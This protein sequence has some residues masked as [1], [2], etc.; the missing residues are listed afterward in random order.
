MCCR[1]RAWPPARST[2]SSRQALP[3]PAGIVVRARSHWTALG[4]YLF[5]T[6][7]MT[8]PLARQFGSAIPGD[9]FDGWQNYWN[10]WWM[11]LALVDRVQWPLATDLLYYPTGVT[12]HFHTLNPFN[13]LISL[14]VQLVFGLIPAYNV[15]VL[16]S[17]VLSGYG[18]FLLA[19]W[20][21]RPRGALALAP[22]SR[23]AAAF[24]AGM[25]FAFAP[26]HMA[27][28]LGHM[29]VFAYQWIPFAVLYLLRALDGARAGRSWRRDALWGGLFLALAGLCDWYFVL[30]LALFAGVALL[31][32]AI[33]AA[34]GHGVRG[35]VQPALV[36]IV[37]GGMGA[38]LLSPLLVP[39]VIE[40][41]RYDF[42]VRPAS[43]LYVLSAS[44]LDFVVPNRLHALFRPESF[45]WPGNQIAP[46]SERTIALGYTTLALAGMSLAATITRR[47]ALP[48]VLAAGFFVLLALGPLP[49]AGGITEATI[50]AN[51][52]LAELSPYNLL[53][54]LVPFMRI[55]RS[56][57]RFA[58]MV[59]LCLSMAAA[60]GLA[61]LLARWPR[62][63]WLAWGAGALLLAEYWVA[64]FPMSPPDTPAYY[65]SLAAQ[66]VDPA[67]PALLNL[68]M[69][70]D[71]PGYLLYQTV[72]GRPL[73]VAYISRDDPRTLTE[74]VPL[75]QHLRHLGP[76]IIDADLG[77]AGPT[78]LADLG[79]GT[80]VLDRYK[81][82][83][84]RERT[85]T[86]G[87][88]AAVFG[89]QTPDFADERITVYAPRLPEEMVSY[90]RLGPDNWGSLRGEGDDRGR[91]IGDAPAAVELR[92]GTGKESLR[93]NY[94]S[95]DLVEVLD[96]A[97]SVL[98]TLATAPQG[99]TAVVAFGGRE[100]LLLRSAESA[101]IR[102]LALE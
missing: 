58:L 59:Q 18:A 38:L 87:V 48:W 41:Q 16:L 14:P 29:Q 61:A 44:L 71:R 33:S 92:H 69:N 85:Y 62:R 36:V 6:L 93:I 77:E 94:Q 86:E 11:R 8:W 3:N 76:D 68:P 80:V 43:D 65:E 20:L 10:L 66:P 50:P 82:P 49:S 42:M 102:R 90:L 19:L 63:Q 91:T 96:P 73:T 84:G 54:A 99:G 89:D 74:R 27:H 28:L 72:H 32:N 12:L 47:R 60:L 15:V 95:G 56:V 13:G 5:L 1:R 64:P 30:Y 97:G 88:A 51:V 39:M 79:V 7:G 70:Y 55:S 83:G 35:A 101:V 17:F 57:S 4:A 45:G 31:W 78:I 75:L 37:W 21:L 26:F 23:M 53:N 9:S 22:G 81:M 2:V 67:R 34:R 25:V 40:A 100:E 24:V 98:V 52:S 46:V